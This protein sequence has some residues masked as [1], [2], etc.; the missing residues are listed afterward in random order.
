MEVVLLL[1]AD[2][3]FEEAVR[4]I[5]RTRCERSNWSSR[6]GVYVTFLLRHLAGKGSEQGALGSTA[7]RYLPHNDVSEALHGDAVCSLPRESD[8][9]IGCEMCSCYSL[10]RGTPICFR[11]GRIGAAVV[12][13]DRRGMQDCEV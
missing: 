12:D 3:F 6:P 8:A 1:F 10:A 2:L 4:R 11:S 9:V 7:I 5:G 13:A